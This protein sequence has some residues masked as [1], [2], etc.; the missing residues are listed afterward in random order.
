[1]LVALG[2]VVL[3]ELIEGVAGHY[4]LCFRARTE[5][6]GKTRNYVLDPPP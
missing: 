1:V 5:A 3:D 4:Q 2:E 6:C